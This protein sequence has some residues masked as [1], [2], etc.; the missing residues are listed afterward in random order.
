MALGLWFVD[1]VGVV[2]LDSSDLEMMGMSGTWGVDFVEI[3]QALL[4]DMTL[5]DVLLLAEEMDFDLDELPY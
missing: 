1:G 3:A 2:Q 4:F 5:D